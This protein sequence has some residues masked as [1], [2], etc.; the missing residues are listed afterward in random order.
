M[1]TPTYQEFR[2][3]AATHGWTPKD[4]APFV[5]ADEPER[6]AARLLYHLT[7]IVS[8]RSGF[9][10]DTC[11]L[12]YPIL[13]EVYHRGALDRTLIEVPVETPTEYARTCAMCPQ[14]LTGREGARFCSDLCR[15]R[16]H[17]RLKG[18]VS[19]STQKTPQ[20]RST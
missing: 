19:H 17:R 14:P 2:E 8:F 15:Q 3:L 16:A 11:P 1:A 10:W 13:C 4:I 7:G 5:Q 12:P 18:H 6:T 20:K 9:S